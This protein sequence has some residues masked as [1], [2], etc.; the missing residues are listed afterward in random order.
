MAYNSSM[1]EMLKRIWNW[2]KWAFGQYEPEP[3]QL[4]DDFVE[5]DAW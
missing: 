1:G 5:R 4:K 2:L 3:E